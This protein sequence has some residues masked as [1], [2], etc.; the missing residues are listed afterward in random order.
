MKRMGAWK[1]RLL[2]SGHQNHGF[3]FWSK[4][5]VLV[6]H[7]GKFVF[8]GEMFMEIACQPQPKQSVMD[9]EPKTMAPQK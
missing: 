9:V 7:E 2:C 1:W 6:A 3:F 4:Q 8:W 5:L